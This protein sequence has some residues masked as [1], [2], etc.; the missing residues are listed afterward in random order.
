MKLIKY[1][2]E[3]T[4][5]GILVALVVHG[6]IIIGSKLTTGVWLDGDGKNWYAIIASVAMF[7]SLYA[8]FDTMNKKVSDKKWYQYKYAQYLLV[9][10]FI[11]FP[12]IVWGTYKLT[13][14]GPIKMTVIA[15]RMP[16]YVLQSDGSIQNKYVLKLV[17]ESDKDINVTFSASSP[18]KSQSIIGADTPLFL[19][20]GRVSQY[21]IFIKAPDEELSKEITDIE[22]KVENTE[23][24]KM[25]AKYRTVFNGPQPEGGG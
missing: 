22:F 19:K 4:A 8:L 10:L 15:E 17:N 24:P 9:A 2:L 13:Y 12:A 6:M 5:Y 14:S 1:I 3:C 16:L 23:D 11:V 20:H 25:Q 18:M 21:T 7:G